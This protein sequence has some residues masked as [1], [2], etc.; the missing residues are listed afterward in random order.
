MRPTH[1]KYVTSAE[2]YGKRKMN[3]KSEKCPHC[4]V[5]GCLVGHGRLMGYGEG[6][7]EK[8]QRGWRELCSK[9]YGK[10]G[11]GRTFQVLLADRLYH[12]M[13]PAMKLW[14]LLT[15]IAIGKSIWAAWDKIC[16]PLCH[17]T[18]YR[19]W[20]AF[21]RS[22]T[23]IRTLLCREKPPPK[24]SAGAA[25]T[26]VIE[27]VKAVFGKPNRTADGGPADNPI[28]AFQAHFQRAFLSG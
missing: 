18:G 23:R 28:A 8:I 26:Q 1:T 22:Q 16:A 12:R 13:A 20:H 15:G 10:K 19:L 7:Q 2:E 5:V 4:H 17:D 27:H 21:L 9:R 6:K 11:C 14:R 25:S 24:M 3:R